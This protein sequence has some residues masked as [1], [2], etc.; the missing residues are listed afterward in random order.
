MFEKAREGLL[1]N[2]GIKKYKNG[3]VKN[4]KRGILKW[5]VKMIKMGEWKISKWVVGIEKYQNGGHYI[6]FV[7]TV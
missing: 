7:Y 4:I 6:N 5:G 2:D 1:D 3:D